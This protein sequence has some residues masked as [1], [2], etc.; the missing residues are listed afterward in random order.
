[1]K[2]G[3]FRSRKATVSRARCASA[4][5]C[6]KTKPYTGIS[7]ICLTVAS[8]QENCLYSMVPRQF[9]YG[10][11]VHDISSTTLRLQTFRLQTFRLLLYTSVQDS[12]TSNFCFS[13]LF[14]SILTSTYTVIP[15]YQSYFHW[16]YDKTTYIVSKHCG[17]TIQ[18]V[19]SVKDAY[20]LSIPLLVREISLH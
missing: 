19:L 7:G 3:T 4:P 10:H 18:L 12:Y 9:V 14:S 6:W 13:K 16:H 5:S 15:F 8:W 2:S 11:F 17:M 20:F 1:M